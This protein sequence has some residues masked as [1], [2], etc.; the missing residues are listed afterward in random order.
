MQNM[1]I[2]GN[3]KA[4]RNNVYQFVE[5]DID[6]N[7]SVKTPNYLHG[8]YATNKS[9]E[10]SRQDVATVSSSSKKFSMYERKFRQR[11]KDRDASPRR[12]KT[13]SPD[14]DSKIDQSSRPNSGFEEDTAYSKVQV[15]VNKKQ[16]EFE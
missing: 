13:R 4:P 2:K 6:N 9:A 15:T 16:K 12:S 11:S 8:S 1:P 5:S 14:R 3:R 10:L 7:L